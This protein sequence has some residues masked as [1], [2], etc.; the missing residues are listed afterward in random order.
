MS[1]LIMIVYCFT[2]FLYVVSQYELKQSKDPHESLDNS[3]F[4]RTTKSGFL[5]NKGIKIRIKVW[6][7]ILK[8]CSSDSGPLRLR[9]STINIT[10]VKVMPIYRML[11]IWYLT[12]ILSLTVGDLL[13]KSKGGAKTHTKAWITR[14]SSGRQSLDFSKIKE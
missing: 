2:H 6:V 11:I 8:T 12:V 13:P 3:N 9:L 4:F 1:I 7:W 5:E 10:F 14:I